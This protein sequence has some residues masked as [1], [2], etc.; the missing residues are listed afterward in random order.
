MLF[1]LNASVAVCQLS[2]SSAFKHFTEKLKADIA[3][4]AAIQTQ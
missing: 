3:L 2:N 1:F 4:E